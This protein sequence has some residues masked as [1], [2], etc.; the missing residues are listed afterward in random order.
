M[1]SDYQKQNYKYNE[2]KNKKRI[3]IYEKQI[4][5]GEKEYGFHLQ[6]KKTQNSKRISSFHVSII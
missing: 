1:N 4:R 5:K 2:Q 3:K 6:N